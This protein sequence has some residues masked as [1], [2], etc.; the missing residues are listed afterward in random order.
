MEEKNR[1]ENNETL[2]ER[3]IE[4]KRKKRKNNGS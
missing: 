1:E 3:K 2:V 4:W